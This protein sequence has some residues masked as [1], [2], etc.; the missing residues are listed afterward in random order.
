MRFLQ[1]RIKHRPINSLQLE[2]EYNDDALQKKNASLLGPPW[3]IAMTE[4]S[5]HWIVIIT[6]INRLTA[7]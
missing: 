7:G 2:M 1:H 6:F 3:F 5:L 4:N